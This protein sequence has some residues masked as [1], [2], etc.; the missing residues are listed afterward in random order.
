MCPDVPIVSLKASLGNNPDSLLM[1]GVVIDYLAQAEKGAFY[2]QDADCF[3]SDS[4]FWNFDPVDLGTEY[5]ACAF[6]RKG[7]AE[8]PAFPET[9]LTA[10]NA[11]LLRKYRQLYGIVSETAEN[12]DARGVKV[13]AEAGYPVGRVLETYKDYYDTLQQYWV[14]AGHE[15]KRYRRISGEGETVH[16]IGGTSYLYKSFEKLDHWDYWPLAVHYFN[17]RIL[18]LPAAKRYSARFSGLIEF[19]QS[20]DVLLGNYPDFASGW[21]RKNADNILAKLKAREVYSSYLF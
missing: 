21:R 9:F 20:A 14:I 6:V 2:I 5:A 1:H 19:H 16:H 12:T 17:L 11:P 8:R 4:S 15:G 10:L 13:L 18:E 3:V 7:S